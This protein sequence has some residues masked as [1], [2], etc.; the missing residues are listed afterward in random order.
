ML[1]FC[2][3]GWKK[4]IFAE[5]KQTPFYIWNF[6]RIVTKISHH[7]TVIYINLASVYGSYGLP[8]PIIEL[9]SSS[10]A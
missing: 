3:T 4:I 7:Y 5:I 10:T 9:S 1:G 6:C 2:E 8:L